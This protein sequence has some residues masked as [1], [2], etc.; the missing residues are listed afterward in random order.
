MST[1]KLGIV[2]RSWYVSGLLCCVDLCSMLLSHTPFLGVVKVEL[3]SFVWSL[4]RE[5]FDCQ[6]SS[7]KHH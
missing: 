5:I 4:V 1:L 2:D 3:Y 7:T 6:M